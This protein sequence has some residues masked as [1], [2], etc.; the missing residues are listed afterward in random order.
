MEAVPPVTAV[1]TEPYKGIRLLVCGGRDYADKKHLNEVLDMFHERFKVG[2]LIHGAAKGA[3]MMAGAWAKSKGIQVTP[4]K[5]EWEKYGKSAGYKR[6][7][8][9][10]AMNPDVCIKF[11]G[12]AGS[13]MM[14]GIC[15]KKGIEVIQ[16]YEIL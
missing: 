7:V 4:V 2:E 5:A 14:E 8:V 10:A 6:N 9:M 3:D 16:H 13:M 1:P 12:G 15:L 11:P